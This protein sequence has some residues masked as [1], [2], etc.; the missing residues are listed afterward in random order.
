M[1]KSIQNLTKKVYIVFDRIIDRG[2]SLTYKIDY[3]ENDDFE[4]ELLPDIFG[5]I[6][7]KFLFWT[8]LTIS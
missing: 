5:L 1:W 4:E 2:T 6:Y 3:R 8:N 7:F